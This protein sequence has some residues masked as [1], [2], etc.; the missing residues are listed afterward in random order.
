MFRPER[1]GALDAGMHADGVRRDAGTIQEHVFPIC[2]ELREVTRP[3]HSESFEHRR[4]QRVGNRAPVE[5]ADQSADV[6]VGLD[7]PS[8]R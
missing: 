7:V 6:V 8:C 1:C 3:V 2:D 5:T 4:E